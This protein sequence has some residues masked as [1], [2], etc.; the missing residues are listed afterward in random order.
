M[1]SNL[2]NAQFYQMPQAQFHPM[3]IQQYQPPIQYNIPYNAP[4]IYQAPIYVPPAP[5]VPTSGI[6]SIGCVQTQFGMSCH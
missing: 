2:A 5:V 4:Q 3:Q 6:Q 1:F